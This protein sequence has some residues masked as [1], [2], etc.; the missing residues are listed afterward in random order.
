MAATKK[1]KKRTMSAAQKT[2]LAKGRKKAAANR[3]KVTKKK[4]PAK[5]KTTAKRKVVKTTKKRSPVKMAK[6]K[7]S[8][9]KKGS[10][11]ARKVARRARGFLGKSGVGNMVQDAALAVAG[12][13]AAGF[14]ANK[15]PV[16]DPRIKAALPI[17]AGLGL[18]MTIGKKN[19]L[20]EGIAK[21][22]VIL[23]TVAVVKQF[24]PYIPIDRKSV[25]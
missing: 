12:G 5:K 19:K 13:I 17:V 16:A 2:A 8:A 15:V 3:R 4:A 22:M 14:L 25:V 9:K 1:K 20:A 11:K 18:S 7:S 6:R 10:S 24:A 21:G 23:G